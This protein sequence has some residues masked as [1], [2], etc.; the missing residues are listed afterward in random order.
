MF[1]LHFSENRTVGHL[2]RRQRDLTFNKLGVIIIGKT[3]RSNE[4]TNEIRDLNPLQI[5]TT[6][7]ASPCCP[8]GLVH[9]RKWPVKPCQV[10]LQSK[11]CQDLCVGYGSFS[12]DHTVY[13]F[14]F[15]FLL[16]LREIETLTIIVIWAQKVTATSA[17]SFSRLERSPDA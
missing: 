16:S 14:L 12:I 7:C 5:V 1:F 15:L 11:L 4:N 17:L 8:T 3:A 10:F 9:F 13:V 6:V 2:L